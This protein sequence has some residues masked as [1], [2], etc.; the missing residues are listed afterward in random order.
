M[1][2]SLMRID[3]DPNFAGL[4]RSVGKALGPS[5]DSKSQEVFGDRGF[6]APF[7]IRQTLELVDIASIQDERIALALAPVLVRKVSCHHGEFYCQE[8]VF[9]RR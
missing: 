6:F 1:S 8:G 7:E 9:L 3:G 5:L 2:L 4:G